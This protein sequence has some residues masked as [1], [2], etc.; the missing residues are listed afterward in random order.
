MLANL[1]FFHA[2]FDFCCHFRTPRA[3]V[4]VPVMKPSVLP[5]SVKSPLIRQTIYT[6]PTAKTDEEFQHAELAPITKR[7]PAVHAQPVRSE[8]F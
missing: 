4:T 6:S 3:A 5:S 2:E 8:K 1:D 7:T